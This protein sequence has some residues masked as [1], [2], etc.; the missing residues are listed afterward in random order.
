VKHTRDWKET[1]RS[2]AALADDQR[3]KPEGNAARQKLLQIINEH[4]EAANYE[5]IKALAD[6]DLTMRDVAIMH[7][8]NISTD[9]SWTGTNLRHAIALMERDYKARIHAAD[10][11]DNQRRLQTPQAQLP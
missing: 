9:G 8:R 2:L 11:R 5:P 1:A 3:G 7:S 10:E 4:P 6:R